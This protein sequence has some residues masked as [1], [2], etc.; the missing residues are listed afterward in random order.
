MSIPPAP[1]LLLALGGT[2][3]LLSRWVQT[4]RWFEGAW[5]AGTAGAFWLVVTQDSTV[6]ASHAASQL[7]TTDSLAQA[8][9][10]LALL[11]GTLFGTGSFGISS[12]RERTAERLGFL[13]LIVAGVLLV[14]SATDLISLV[15]SLEIV[16]FAS[17]GLHRSDRTESSDLAHDHGASSDADAGPN[18][19]SE[20]RLWD[21]IISSCCVWMGIAF[22][23][24][25]TAA[26]RYQ[27]IRMVL[28]DAYVPNSRPMIG[29]GSN[30][31]MLAIGLIVAGI[32]SRIGLVPWQTGLIESGRHVR[33]WSAGCI[34]SLGLLSGFLALTRLCGTVWVGFRNEI[35]VILL[36]TA[37]LTGLVS[38][39]L[40]GLGLR[41]GEGR[42]RRW[43]TSILMLQSA[44]L[45]VGVIAVASG[46]AVPDL[47]TVG[48]SQEPGALKVLVFAIA[49][50]QVAIAGLFLT[51]SYLERDGRNVE[52]VEELMGLGSLRPTAAVTLIVI[53]A[54]L[55]GQ[56][57][58]WGFWAHWWLLM[59]GLNVPA[60]VGREIPTSH[61]GLIVLL[62]TNLVATLPLMAVV[63][64]FVRVL[65][66]EQPI[67]R[68]LP[69]GKRAA[70]FVSCGCGLLLIAVG[71]CPAV[72]FNATSRVELPDFKRTQDPPTGSTRGTATARR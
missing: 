4:S 65:L 15:L 56:P 68:T 28:A 23:T 30:L 55:A 36:V 14:S 51:L 39:G 6:D 1:T 47:R 69:Q 62:I 54:S 63:L 38:A 57:L 58:L 19:A 27:E 71:I 60:V 45:S 24:A 31:G 3:L 67:S 20:F 12:P 64:R 48:A 5:L 32:G 11:T 40:A 52:F 7:W 37:G 61:P 9:Q 46:L 17:W 70:L 43:T 53:L 18:G 2:T 33:Y 26:T 41:N 34:Q 8:G 49:A 22:L 50:G 21:G 59:S 29:S 72:A 16:Q 25:L 66:L 13:S 44:W 35:I 10:C 42:L